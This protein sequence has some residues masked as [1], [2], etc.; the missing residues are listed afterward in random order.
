[1]TDTPD[2]NQAALGLTETEDRPQPRRIQSADSELERRVRDFGIQTARLLSDAHSQDVIVFDV[3]GLSD[4]T[5]YI[6]IATGTSDRQIRSTADDLQELGKEHGFE[7]YGKDTDGSATW[8][9][10]DFV[11]VVVHLFDAGTRAHY[12]LE[13][14]WG[15]APQVTWQRDASA[16]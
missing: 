11:D 1:M 6:V 13:M 9:V 15:D 7:R 14:L 3:R 5:D 4:V 8:S 12:D 2:R 10:V 16:G